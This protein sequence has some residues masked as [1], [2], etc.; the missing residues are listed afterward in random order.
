[1]LWIESDYTTSGEQWAYS[2]IRLFEYINEIF[3]LFLTGLPAL[4]G[5]PPAIEG[6][7]RYWEAGTPGRR[8][9]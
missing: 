9:G 7:K 6:A 2:S 1:M 3:L 4:P 5:T 8:S